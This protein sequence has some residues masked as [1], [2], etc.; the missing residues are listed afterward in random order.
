MKYFNQYKNLFL[1]TLILIFFWNFFIPNYQKYIV[2]TILV[3]FNQSKISDI[4]V[5][6]V[7]LLLFFWTYS[8]SKIRFYLKNSY[9]VYSLFLLIACIYIRLNY[10]SSLLEMYYLPKIKYF[11][12]LFILV[13]IP[14]I[15][16]LGF[17]WQNKRSK[18]EESDFFDDSP[19]NNP[20]EDILNRRQKAIQVS[21]LIKGNKSK[22]SL[23]IGIVGE[24]GNGKTS[25]MG[26]VEKSFKDDNK[27]II[28]HFNSWLNISIN[29][30]IND[31]FNTVEKEISIYSLDI[32]KEIKKYGNNVLSINKNSITET[33]LNAIKVIPD[34]SLSEDFNT[35]NNLL[36]KLDK[37]VIVF[38]DD[39]DRLQPNEVFEVLKL[40]RNTASFDVFNYVVGYDKAYLNEALE[41]YN[42]PFSNKYYEKIFLKEF[43]L[44]PITQGQINSFIKE[45]I[46]QIIPERQHE[47]Q[48]FFE[49]INIFILYNDENVFKSINNIRNAKRFLNEFKIS[50]EKVK[51][52]IYLEDFILIK[53]LK[54]SYY[55]VYRL[56]FNKEVYI[57]VNNDKFR[58]NYKYTHYNLR[59][60]EGKNNS[61]ASFGRAFDGSLLKEDV[62]SLKVFSE[63]E[64]NIISLICERIFNPSIGTNNI[65]RNSLIYGHNYYRY[66]ED[67]IYDSE[68]TN[69]EFNAFMKVSYQQKKN[70]VDKAYTEA[71]LVGL[72]LFIYKVD[73]YKDIKSKT[74]YEDFIKILFYIANLKSD[75]EFLNYHGIDLDFLDNNISNYQ[76]QLIIKSWYKNESE[77]KLF[78]RSIF[79]EDK[80]YYYFETDFV[81]HLYDKHGTNSDFNIPF[82]KYEIEEYLIY[83]F[84]NDSKSITSIDKN[85]WHCYRLCFVKDWQQLSSNSWK[86]TEKIIKKNKQKI[87]YKIIPKLYKEFLIYCVTTPQDLYGIER[88]SLK[89]GLPSDFLK[90]LFGSHDN[91]IKYLESN[92]F[93]DKLEQPYE[94]LDEFL[95]F[96]KE[97]NKAGQF[98][99]FDFTY[100]PLLKKLNKLK[101]HLT[102]D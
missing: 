39:L 24:W 14:V 41:K 91:F 32:S 10:E 73:I 53:L 92:T 55:D 34:N 93:K 85:F 5:F 46:L 26:F 101:L 17:W 65:D 83:C 57:E 50:I 42:I 89:L 12:V 29:S 87:L 16:L 35:L 22:T 2:D 43:P 79:Y 100:P 54:F 3:H 86:S 67:E 51:N 40:I 11:D 81:K 48:A 98:I 23:A 95:V 18:S 80:E 97:V 15:L 44:P 6:T 45:K 72:L 52:D 4:I 74:E 102:Y 13:I 82:S 99:Q 96:A 36:N 63:E 66:F 7:I 94:F 62:T 75:S 31:F 49:Y 9:I 68:I 71:R 76:D 64:L 60:K 69:A 20:D 38:F 30:I 61:F 84:E 21:R 8:K 90:K 1:I 58:G 37:K 25:F 59:K 33:L 56:L 19:I 88:D 70:I 78:F 27:Y 77:I 28:V 47:I